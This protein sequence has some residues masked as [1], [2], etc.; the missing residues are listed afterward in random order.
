MTEDGH[1]GSRSTGRAENNDSEPFFMPPDEVAQ[2]EPGGTGSNSAPES[3]KVKKHKKGLLHKRWTVPVPKN[4]K[5]WAIA[6]GIAILF[7]GTLVGGWWFLFKPDTNII[8]KSKPLEKV[9]FVPKPTTVPSKLSGLLVEPAVNERP[10]TAVMIENSQEARPQSGLKDAS[11]V[12]E[13]IAEGGITRFNALFQDTQPD[14][15]GP[16]RSIRPY[17]I[18]WFW[19]FDASI[20]HVGGS[21]KGLAD[22]RSLGIRDLDQFA[23]SGAYHRVA[24]RYAPHNVYSSIAKLN[25]LQQAK[26]FTTANFTG[27]DRKKEAASKTPTATKI[28][29][30]ISSFFFNVHYDY[31]A[32]TNSY[33]RSE[34]GEVHRD[35]R[36]GAQLA[37]KVVIAVVMQRGIDSDGQHTAYTTT[38]SGKVYVFQDGVV[39]EGTWGKASRQ[40]QWTFAD[41]AGAAISF[42]PGQTW[43]TMVD[44]PGSVIAKP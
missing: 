29:L 2:Q 32:A 15:I 5:Q 9:A 17:Y 1:L 8:D 21:P 10:V 27:F 39:T 7:L 23:N 34:G 3:P 42:N 38:G 16:I 31:D 14:F 11:V 33:L 43:I 37:P 22:I 40:A 26:G 41:A 19:P 25:E 24:E 12:F 44:T 20:A 6:S 35:L 28:D 13:A 36:S 30:N 4:T 18:D